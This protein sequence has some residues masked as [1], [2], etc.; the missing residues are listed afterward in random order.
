MLH[1]SLLNSLRSN[2]L[3]FSQHS[4]SYELAS[5]RFHIPQY[6]NERVHKKKYKSQ[7]R[8]KLKDLKRIKLMGQRSI[9]DTGE[10]TPA[11]YMPMRYKLFLKMVKDRRECTRHTRKQMP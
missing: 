6:P 10:S 2:K 8:Q 5:R 9:K 4:Q 1:R 3:L 11:F 7:Q